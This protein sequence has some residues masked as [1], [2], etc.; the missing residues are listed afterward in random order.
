[1]FAATVSVCSGAQWGLSWCKKG[2]PLSQRWP[3]LSL[4]LT[5]AARGGLHKYEEKTGSELLSPRANCRLPVLPRQRGSAGRLLKPACCQGQGIWDAAKATQQHLSDESNPYIYCYQVNIRFPYFTE[6][7][8]HSPLLYLCVW[9]CVT[10]YP[11]KCIL[12]GFNTGGCCAKIRCLQSF[13]GSLSFKKA[14]F[15][16]AVLL[17]FYALFGPAPATFLLSITAPR[18]GAYWAQSPGTS[19]SP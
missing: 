16:L 8:R 17:G 1:M 5:K 15:P 6:V 4:Q 3:G 14:D 2:P 18:L 9:V 19:N 11:R 7:F 10:S 12:Y 13:Y